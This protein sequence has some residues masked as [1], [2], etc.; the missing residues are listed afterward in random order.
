MVITASKLDAAFNPKTIAIVGA[1]KSANYSWLRNMDTF[2]GRVYSVQVDPDEIPGIEELGIP[3]YKTISEIPDEIDFVVIAVPRNVV[4]IV[5]SDALNKGVKNIHVFSSGFAES[6]ETEA[7]ELQTKIANMAYDADV[8]LVGPNCMGIFNPSVG[9]RFNQGQKINEPGN[10]TFLSQ[11]GGHAGTL[12]EAAQANGIGINKTISFGNAAVLDSPDLLE[13]FAQDQLTEIITMYVEGP[14]DPRRFFEVLKD[15]S[16][17]K[18]VVLWK[19]GQTEDGK[20][21]SASHTGSLTGSSEVWDTVIRQSGAIRAD[22]LTEAIDIT[23][24][25]VYLAPTTNRNIG[26]IGGTGGQSVSMADAFAKNNMPVPR[27]SHDSLASLAGFFQL[28]GAAYYNPIDIGGLNRPMLSTIVETLFGDPQIGSV[29]IQMG[30]GLLQGDRE[31]GLGQIE[32]YESV[33]DKSGKPAFVIYQAA[34]PYE[35][36]DALN[37]LDIILRQKGFPSF[38]D[39]DRAAKAINK[40]VSYHSFKSQAV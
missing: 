27:L 33:R 30:S 19:G 37:E 6:G 39:P 10:V 31:D 40:M 5:L 29:G 16:K 21:A 9:M 17:I 28:V 4:P 11:S 24:A 12:V 2:K 8:V 15:V 7:I 20:R 1:K 34:N 3:N 35:E 32:L 26:I 14:R 23:K 22:S 18:P 13:Y 36:G 25:F 38:P